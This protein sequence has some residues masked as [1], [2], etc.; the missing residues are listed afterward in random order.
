MPD[1]S[2]PGLYVEE[3][4]SGPRPIAGVSTSNAGFVGETERGP[5]TP[6][7]VTSWESY[8]QWF[9]GYIDGQSNLHNVFLP[10]AV[11]GF[12]DNG[13]RRL[14]VARVVGPAAATASVVLQDF[15]AR[16]TGP[17]A[18]G[19]NLLVSVTAA[20]DAKP[21][22]AT[23]D[24]FRIRIAYYLDAVPENF[25][26]PTDP[27]QRGN[28]DRLEPA[29][30]EDYD[31]LSG[32]STDANY[33]TTVV[34][35]SSCLLRA[36]TCVGRPA[37]VAFPAARLSGG[38]SDPAGLSDYLAEHTS[39]TELRR[40]LAGLSAI[41]D[42]SLI[43]AP[44]EVAVPGLREKVIEACELLKDR[45]AVS[46]VDGGSTDIANVRPSTD[47]NWGAVYYPWIRV[48]ASH[49][50]EGHRLIPSVGHVA[51]IYARVDLERGV[52]KPPANE[53]VQGTVAGGSSLD[54]QP[55]EVTVGKNEQDT[56]NARA[57]NVI[58]D[59]RAQGRGIRLLSARTMS[60]DPEWKYINVRRL[61]IFLEQSLDRG[62]EWVVFEPNDAV[63]WGA[64]RTSITAF[65]RTVWR[66]GALTGA[67]EDEAFFVK[68]DRTTMT[69]DDIDNG[70]LICLIGVAPLR[71]AEFVIFRIFQKTIE[72]TKT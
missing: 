69:Q 24:W 18:W 50:N 20:S 43:A 65:L 52:H 9:G 17:G 46:S 28:P 11:R 56:L 31:N 16:A 19:N 63:T 30:F 64:L 66:N 13:G 22:T 32:S 59:F 48:P 7:V 26:D 40:G 49:T 55:L 47:T 15:A 62:T 34:N 41:R 2:A 44:D 53:V 25:V 12:F 45:F 54:P 70:R 33:A 42:I 8:Q 5:T 4:D 68:C 72:D 27:A 14:F 6:T 35:A 1:Y 3:L 38:V 60:S 37:E 58:R 23:A 39:N 71:P 67:T 10:Y 61:F 57:V 36:T 51:G 21:G 29:A